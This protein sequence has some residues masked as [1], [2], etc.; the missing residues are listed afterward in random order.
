MS[1]PC[2]AFIFVLVFASCNKN[3]P[4]PIQES[5][6]FQMGFTTWPYGPNP[7]DVDD[8]YAYLQANGDIYAEH[9]DN[10]IPW[11][12]LINDSPLPAEFTQSMDFKV[13]KRLPNTNLLLSVSLLN[14]DRN[15]LATDLDGVVPDYTSFSDEQIEDAYFEYIDYLI[16]RFNPDY[17]VSAIEANELYINAPDQ[18]EGYKELM[19]K[20]NNRISQA[21][22]D[23]KISESMTLHNLYQPQVAAPETYLNE[24]FDYMNQMDFAAISFYPFFK[25]LQTQ[26]DFQEAFDFMHDRL[27]VPIAFAETAHIAEDLVVPNLNLSIPGS[28]SEQDIYLKTLLTNAEAQNYEFVIW[29]AHRDYDALWETFPPELQDIGQL[30]RDSGILNEEGN[31]RLSALTWRSYL[32]EK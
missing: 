15:D 24:V 21:Y 27:D 2:I 30:W 25:D 13:S 23:L 4:E 32:S 1:R 17:L 26:E 12:A 7:E 5:R 10:N 31:E 19:H 29:W 22:P 11:N 18:W 6:N 28:E 16:G 20:V 8:T 3:E 14:L 9:I